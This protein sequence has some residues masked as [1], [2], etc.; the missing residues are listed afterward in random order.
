M[1]VWLHLIQRVSYLI[2]QDMYYAIFWL[3]YRSNWSKEFD[4]EWLFWVNIGIRKNLLGPVH[5][6]LNRSPLTERPLSVT[7]LM[8]FIVVEA[9]LA[10]LTR[11]WTVFFITKSRCHSRHCNTSKVIRVTS[12]FRPKCFQTR[13]HNSWPLSLLLPPMISTR[14]CRANKP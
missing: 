9:S 14:H 12:R 11:T 6:G 8:M 1:L 10:S 5:R 13:F 2:K 3:K 7:R 4:F